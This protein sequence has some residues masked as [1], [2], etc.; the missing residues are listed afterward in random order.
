MG[1]SRIGY[2]ETAVQVAPLSEGSTKRIDATLVPIESNL[3]IVVTESRMEDAGMIKEN[4]EQLKL[5]P[6]TTGNP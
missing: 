6:T 5:L 2:K 3:E 1:F 4:M